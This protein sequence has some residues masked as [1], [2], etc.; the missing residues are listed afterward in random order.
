METY[1]KNRLIFWIL[2]VLVVINVAALASFFVY[3]SRPAVASCKGQAGMSCPGLCQ[4]LNLTESQGIK[5]E[6]INREYREQ[7]GVLS[8]GIKETRAAILD[9][10][11]RETPDT[12]VI[13]SLVRELSDRQG[14]LQHENIRQYL[15]LKKVCTPEQARQL[16]GLYRDLYGCQMQGKG[17]M[18]RNRHKGQG[19]KMRCE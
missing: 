7:A 4:E 16:S 14:R 2:I 18:N 5:V 13:N 6:V 1:K 10:L 8:A 3:S 17:M 11:N 15:E 12:L 9:E 19:G